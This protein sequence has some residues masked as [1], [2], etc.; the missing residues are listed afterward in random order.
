MNADIKSKRIP[1]IY[2]GRDPDQGLDCI[3][4][5]SYVRTLFSQP[6]FDLLDSP[7]SIALAK[8]PTQA[9]MPVDLPLDLARRL[10][11]PQ[12]V[13]SL[14]SL[15]I[16]RIEGQYLVA[17]SVEEASLAFMGPSGSFVLP[18]NRFSGDQIAGIFDPG[19]LKKLPIE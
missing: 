19:R 11:N 3:G 2:G 15:V 13:P 8:Y 16:L 10:C 1:F 12:G 4:F 14:L 6:A 17:T 7:L 18:I 9:E 5:A